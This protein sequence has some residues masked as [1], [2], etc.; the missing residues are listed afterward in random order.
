MKPTILAYLRS[1]A[2]GMDNKASRE[3]V[4]RYVIT[5]L[6]PFEEGR[7][8][9][10]WLE[11]E[12]RRVIAATPEICSI[13]GGYFIARTADEARVSYEYHHKRGMSELTR[14]ARIRDAYPEIAQGRLF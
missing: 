3:E 7:P 13:Q 11:R 12:V 5:N 6:Y 4:V 1:R 2:V 8:S 10:S 14:A 9:Y